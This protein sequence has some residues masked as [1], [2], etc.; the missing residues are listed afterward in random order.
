MVLEKIVVSQ[1]QLL[2][3]D[4]DGARKEF[5]FGLGDSISTYLAISKVRKKIYE[6]FI[7]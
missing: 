2:S 6:A 4:S 5:L 7:W 1:W 3:S